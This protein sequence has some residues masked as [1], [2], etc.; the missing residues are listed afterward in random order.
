MT[1]LTRFRRDESGAATAWSIFWTVIFLLLAGLVIDVANAYRYR[2]ALQATA[3]ASALGTLMAYK[4]VEKFSAYMGTGHVDTNDPEARGKTAGF[5]MA[6][7]NMD[8]VKNKTNVATRSNI[9]I[10]RWESGTFTPSLTNPNAARV[11]ALRSDDNGNG[12]DMLLLN[13]FTALGYWNV[14]AVAIAEAYK[15]GC[16]A[17]EGIMA[18]GTLNMSSNNEFRG[19]LC[20]H[21]E[22][23]VD[24]QNNNFFYDETGVSYGQQGQICSGFS[25]CGEDVALRVAPTLENRITQEVDVMPDVAR[26]YSDIYNTILN[27]DSALTDPRLKEFIPSALIATRDADGFAETL[28]HTSGA[29]LV[30]QHTITASAF[31]DLIEDAAAPVYT[32]GELVGPDLLSAYKNDV[33]IVNSCTGNNKTLKIDKP[34]VISDVVILTECDVSFD[35]EMVM[36]NTTLFTT[37]GEK[38]SGRAAVSG[39]AA[40]RIGTGTCEDPDGASQIFAAGDIKFAGQSIVEHS[41]LLSLNDVEYAAQPDAS[42]GTLIWAGRDVKITSLGLWNGCI[43]RPGEPRAF[44]PDKYRLVY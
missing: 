31:N 5:T 3:D 36:S 44:I 42:E 15:A 28:H 11:T 39:S 10:G 32:N 41:Q 14:G 40:V 6:N 35:S 23:F 34:I 33:L 43:D 16:P 18:G 4:D 7:T 37:S 21:G 26:L 20:L 13:A 12:L 2:A 17:R 27:P 29:G 38:G 25:T 9:E 1:T 22:I 8:P 24:L 30:E 19:D